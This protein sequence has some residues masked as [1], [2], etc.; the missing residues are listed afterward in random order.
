MK[1]MC[2]YTPSGP[3][4]VRTGWGHA[5]QAAGHDFRFWVR[6]SKSAFDAF[7]D[8]EPDLY[9]GTTY[10]LDRPTAKCIAARP[11][12]RVALFASAWGPLID[13]ID[14][15]KYPVVVVSEQEKA[16]IQRLKAET[17]RPDFVFIHV[18]GK[19]LEETMGG[20]RSIGVEP[21]GV[22]NAADLHDYY[23]GVPREALKCDV[24]FVGGYWGYKARNIDRYLLPLLG[25]GTDAKLFGNKTWPVAEF[26]GLIEDRNVRDLFASATVCPNVSEPHSTDLGFDIIERPFKVLSAGGFCVSDHVDEMREVFSEDELPTAA[27]PKEFHSKVRYFVRNPGERAGYMER[28]R[29][30]VLAAHTY[31]DRVAQMF[32]QLRLPQEAA[33]VLAAKAKFLEG[34]K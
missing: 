28:G 20:W 26:L 8:F 9:I 23:R 31:H 14:K 33:N 27:T 6:E 21:V 16:T 17:G 30:K 22:L 11:N 19:Y 29:A 7:R 3:H 34:V 24:A 18:T 1:V 32:A 2:D 5:F 12:L 13:R 10:D 25:G 15:A 4:Y